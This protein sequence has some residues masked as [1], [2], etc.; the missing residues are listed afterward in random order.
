MHSIHRPVHAG[1]FFLA[2]D[3]SSFTM[4]RE[5]VSISLRG[6]AVSFF[7][8]YYFASSRHVSGQGDESVQEL[9]RLQSGVRTGHEPWE[10]PTDVYETETGF[11]IRIELAGVHEDDIDIAMCGGAVVIGGVRRDV[12]PECKRRYR[13]ME[14]SHGRFERRVALP[15]TVDPARA[16]ATLEGGMLRI[17]IPQTKHAAVGSTTVHLRCTCLHQ[18]I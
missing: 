1:R 4:K 13:Q 8:K 9:L 10:P 12:C 14:I 16:E 6:A 3:A 7:G 11:V 18:N 15:N 2:Q 5:W 17:S